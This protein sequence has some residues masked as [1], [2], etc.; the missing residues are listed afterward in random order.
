LD[1]LTDRRYRGQLRRRRRR[2]GLG[3]PLGSVTPELGRGRSRGA[4]VG[5]R[6]GP[7]EVSGLSRSPTYVSR[8]IG[9]RRRRRGCCAGVGWT[10]SRRSWIT[11][12][13]KRRR[14]RRR[15]SGARWSGC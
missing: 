10:V 9:E 4:G 13:V 7:L 5:D 12:A 15:G 1:S 11:I 3:G 6:W 8:A 2:R 14:R